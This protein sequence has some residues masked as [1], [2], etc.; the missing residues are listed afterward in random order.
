MSS[1]SE[2]SEDE[3]DRLAA[4]MAG[5]DVSG[6]PRQQGIRNPLRDADMGVVLRHRTTK[7]LHFGHVSQS[8]LLGCSRHKSINHVQFF[9]DPEKFWPKCGD[10]FSL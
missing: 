8:G 4:Q 3:L 10:C 6:N 7:M 5:D 1:D 2:A 9:E